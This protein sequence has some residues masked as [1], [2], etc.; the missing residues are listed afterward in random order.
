MDI[1]Y[2]IGLTKDINSS[3]VDITANNANRSWPK[4]ILRITERIKKQ[5]PRYMHNTPLM[6]KSNVTQGY[7]T[8]KSKA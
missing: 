8:M 4:L 1:E 5:Y 2:H 7:R 3:P 6:V